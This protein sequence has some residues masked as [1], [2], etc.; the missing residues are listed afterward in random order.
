[1][2]NIEFESSVT[3]C[4]I[5]LYGIPVWIISM[6]CFSLG[7]TFYIIAQNPASLVKYEGVKRLVV[8]YGHTLVWF[9]LGLAALF[10]QFNQPQFSKVFS[11]LALIVYVIYI[12]N[13]VS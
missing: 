6:I 13:L 11:F 8:L 5:T 2:K 9:L 3:N 4:M 12:F 1:M 7:A 10:I